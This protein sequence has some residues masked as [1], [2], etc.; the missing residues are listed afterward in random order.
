MRKVLPEQWFSVDG[1][2]GPQK[3]PHPAT[4]GAGDKR[5][6]RRTYDT[7]ILQD[8]FV[9][10]GIHTVSTTG[11]EASGRNSNETGSEIGLNAEKGHP[12]HEQS[13]MV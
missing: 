2:D 7:T 4:F 3:S 12:V 6:K 8:T 5:V 9:M 13:E 1:S 11:N 10:S